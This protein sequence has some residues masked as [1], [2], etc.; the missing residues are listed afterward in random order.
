MPEDY[1][2]SVWPT[3]VDGAA[4]P[5][6]SS[7]LDAAQRERDTSGH[8]EAGVLEPSGHARVGSGVTTSV[9]AL[10]IGSWVSTAQ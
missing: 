5:Q 7:A 4:V 9:S 1:S 8:W 3:K 2:T 10:G 6:Q